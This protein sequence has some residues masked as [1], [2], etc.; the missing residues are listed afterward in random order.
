MAES[1]RLTFV[2][3]AWPENVYSLFHV[4]LPFPPNDGLY[5][6]VHAEQS[7]GA[8]LGHI[9]MRGERG[10]LWISASDMLRQRWNPSYPYLEERVLEFLGL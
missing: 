7:P 2:R 8:R 5:G 9:A 6:G 10:V 4:A 1:S 3:L